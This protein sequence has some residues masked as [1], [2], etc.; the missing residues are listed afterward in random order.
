[1][2][3]KV[4]DRLL[5]VAI[6]N[7]GLF[8]LNATGETAILESPCV[9]DPAS[10]ERKSSKP[11]AWTRVTALAVQRFIDTVGVVYYILSVAFA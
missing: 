9:L 10:T 6:L 5:G 2:Y 11:S 7:L 3:D 8:T 1:M 4:N